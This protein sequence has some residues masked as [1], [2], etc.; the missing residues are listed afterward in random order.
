MSVSQ[1]STAP[2]TS[3]R[4]EELPVV[5][6]KA[7]LNSS[8]THAPTVE[9]GKDPMFE[10]SIR[11]QALDEDAPPTASVNDI[12]NT[13]YPDAHV[14]SFSRS[15]GI[16]NGQPVYSPAARQ[17][18]HNNVSLTAEPLYVV[19]FGYLSDKY[20][21]TV[22]YFKQLGDSTEPDTHAEVVNAFRIGYKQPVDAMRAI[23]KNGEIISG[24]WM[25]GTKWEN[26]SRAEAIFGQA[27]A[28][29]NL[30]SVDY[31]AP[32]GTTSAPMTDGMNVDEPSALVLS[33]AGSS[34]ARQAP[35]V[36]TP[37][38]LAPSASAYRKP[39][40]ATKS[41]LSAGSGVA[42]PLAIDASLPSSSK[43][44]LGQ[45]TDLVFGW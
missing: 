45:L 37:I 35:S 7:K 4:F 5:Q 42:Q 12:V 15:R 43:G 28:R 34:N 14:S 33:R 24:S 36:G 29:S 2:S 8:L 32:G 31:S 18:H 26:P 9:F 39:G 13:T 3:P 20:S 21:I 11:R 19:V 25:V 38:H 44:V 41:S 40:A 16:P 10:S 17:P 30:Q 1:N 23:R 27:V 22:E 6:T